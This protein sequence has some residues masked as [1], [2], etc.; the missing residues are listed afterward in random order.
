MSA[1]R[2]DWELKLFFALNS[3]TGKAKT[4]FAQTAAFSSQYSSM[5]KNNFFTLPAI[6]S[7]QTSP[8]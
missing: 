3:L 8:A 5:A 4:R 2:Y 7:V 1:L 6:R